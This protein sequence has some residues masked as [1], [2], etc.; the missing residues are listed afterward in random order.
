LYLPINGWPITIEKGE[1][2]EIRAKWLTAP[3]PLFKGI[4]RHRTLSISI[5]VIEINR[6]K[7]R[8]KPENRPEILHH[9]DHFDHFCHSS[10]VFGL[11]TMQLRLPPF[12]RDN[13][14]LAIRLAVHFLRSVRSV[15]LLVADLGKGSNCRVPDD[16]F[17]GGNAEYTGLPL[18]G[19]TSH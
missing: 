9:F 3:E 14:S 13:S 6:R 7:D 12:L 2:I 4:Q 1:L 15:T 19:V 11:N 18:A 5:I 8:S 16:S 17:H 10:G